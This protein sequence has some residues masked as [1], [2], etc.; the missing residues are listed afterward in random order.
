MV[1]SD[2][3]RA[4][5]MIGRL[6]HLQRHGWVLLTLM[7]R[8]VAVTSLQQVAVHTDG[9]HPVHSTLLRPR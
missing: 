8:E 6:N 7:L 2:V 9:V 3:V 4:P 5:G 1:V